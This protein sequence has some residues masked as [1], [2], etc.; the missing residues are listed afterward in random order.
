M[1]LILKDDS[2]LV[3]SD[4]ITYFSGDCSLNIYA[5]SEDEAT[6]GQLEVRKAEGEAIYVKGLTV[7]GGKIKAVGSNGASATYG[8][9]IFSYEADMTVYSGIVEAISMK[10]DAICVSGSKLTIHGGTVTAKCNGS[11]IQKYGINAYGDIII[12][13]GTVYAGGSTGNDESGAGIK[14]A[15]TKTL[16]ITGG[17]LTAKGGFCNNNPGAAGI[18]SALPVVY[19]GG[20]MTAI[21]GYNSTTNGL[22]IA[23]D[24]TATP[25]KGKITN[26]SGASITYYLTTA[27]A[28]DN[29]TWDGGH[30][31]AA[32]TTTGDSDLNN[33]GVT[34]E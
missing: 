24:E 15:D 7:H 27:Y 16:T 21:G 30:S 12:N 29:P 4:G 14:L 5:Q 25:T 26:N 13:G 32:S 18:V 22:C 10:G 19:K 11:D 3:V 33:V 6:M 34:I 20:K 31:L 17:S 8:G 9:A 1:N 2:K 23:A 28:I